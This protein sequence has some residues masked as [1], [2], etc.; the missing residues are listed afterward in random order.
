MLV[1]GVDVKETRLRLV[2]ELSVVAAHPVLALP[3]FSLPI[4]LKRH[5]V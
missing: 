3:S 2:D 5:V 4:A 1:S